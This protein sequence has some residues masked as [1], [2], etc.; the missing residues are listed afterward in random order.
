MWS[1]QGLMH[2]TFHVKYIDAK[3][4]EKVVLLNLDFVFQQKV[5]TLTLWSTCGR[6]SGVSAYN[7]WEGVVCLGNSE[8]KVC[9]QTFS[10]PLKYRFQIWDF[11]TCKYSL[12]VWKWKF[13][14]RYLNISTTVNSSSALVIF[15][16]IHF[17]LL[18]EN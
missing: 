11:W 5:S 1:N 15:G 17:L 3:I 18:P 6:S 9:I 4:T 14:I 12:L 8:T 7:E 16:K 2:K 13:G 10:V